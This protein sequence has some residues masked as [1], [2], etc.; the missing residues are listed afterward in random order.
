MSLEFLKLS[1]RVDDPELWNG[2]RLIDKNQRNFGCGNKGE[3]EGQEGSQ[4]AG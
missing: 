3:G 1:V 4:W 2:V